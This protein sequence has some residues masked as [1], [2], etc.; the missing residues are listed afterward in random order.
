MTTQTGKTV[1]DK[2][3]ILKTNDIVS[4]GNSIGYPITWQVADT[5]DRR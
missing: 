4:T 5:D 1:K 3:K 2:I